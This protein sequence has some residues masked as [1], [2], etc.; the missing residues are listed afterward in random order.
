MVTLLSS[1]INSFRRANLELSEA[2]NI[3]NTTR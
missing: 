1:N 3:V 2:I